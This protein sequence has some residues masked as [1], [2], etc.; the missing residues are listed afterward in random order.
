M[1]RD[2][3]IA[4][5]KR[6]RICAVLLLSTALCSCS[7]GP[8]PP[9]DSAGEPTNVLMISIDSLRA[10]HLAAYGYHRETSP[11]IDRLAR[12]GVLFERMIA[13]SSWTLPSHL[14]MLTGLS[15]WAHGAMFDTRRLDPGVDTLAEILGARG[16]RTEGFASG[17]YLHPIFGFADGFD[18]YELLAETVYDG[19]GFRLE[20]LGEEPRLLDEME[21]SERVA[22]GARTSEVLA[23]KVEEALARSA[24]GPFFLF[25]HMFDVHY[26]YDPP[27]EYWRR[28]NPDYTGEM[29]HTSFVTDPRVRPGMPPEER[30]QLMAL[31]DGEIFWTDEHVGR[32]LAELERYGVSDRTLVVVVGDHGEEF[33]DHGKKGHRHTLYDEQLLVPFILRLPGRLPA[34]ERIKMQ[35]R[36]VDI[37]P[38]LLDV[39][40][41][42]Q[43]QNLGGESLLPFVSGDRE[44]ADLAAMSYLSVGS[45]LVRTLRQ[46]GSKLQVRMPLEMVGRNHRGRVELFDLG[47]DPEEQTALEEGAKLEAAHAAFEAAFAEE[48]ALRERVHSGSSGVIS[49]PPALRRA[50]EALGYVEDDAS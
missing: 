32:M 33:F 10:D 35:V 6:W 50:L 40:G 20:Q 22:Q 24:A 4:P 26:D 19:D 1:S 14:T 36:M 25:V 5:Q 15:S 39:L 49:L 23:R 29:T 34:G 38:T 9:A 28:F 17:P 30:E 16:Y 27:E 12:E 7:E 2:G 21:L 43:P 18:T 42:P 44:E 45:I 3:A 47:A 41:V 8:E 13:D 48:Q 11:H 31:Y 37:V 46:P